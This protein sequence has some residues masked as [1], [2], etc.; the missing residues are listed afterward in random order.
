MKQFALCI[1]LL[2]AATITFAQSKDDRAARRSIW[3]KSGQSLGGSIEKLQQLL[4][5]DP[6]N[7]SLQLELGRAYYAIAVK[8]RGASYADAQRAFEKILERDPKN[9]VALAYHGSALG[10][11]IGN[12]LVPENQ[13]AGTAL[14]AIDELD[15]A[16]ALAPDSIEVR[17]M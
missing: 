17:Q 11:Q 12:N 13:I 3:D 2:C 14:K 7:V 6:D 5:A 4:A 9:A 10:L 15:R 16:V 8:S 1:L